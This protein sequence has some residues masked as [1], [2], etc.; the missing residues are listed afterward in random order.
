[1]KK[2]KWILLALLLILIVIGCSKVPAGYVGVKVYLLGTSKGVD[3]EEV[4]VGWVYAEFDC[5]FY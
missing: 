5:I 1:M 3:S 2:L 4:G